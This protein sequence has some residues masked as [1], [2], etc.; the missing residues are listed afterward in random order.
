M[1]TPS[2]H[3]SFTVC[4]GCPRLPGYALYP[5]LHSPGG[6]LPSSQQPS[7]T[8]LATLAAACSANPACKGFSWGELKGSLL[9]YAAWETVPGMQAYEW[10][11]ASGNCTGTW[12]KVEAEEGVAGVQPVVYT[13]RTVLFLSAQLTANSNALSAV[14]NLTIPLTITRTN[15]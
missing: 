8:T 6:A 14:G 3:L 4:A 2:V 10:P 9:P 5:S 15:R 12:V 13:N 1:L 7:D 11:G